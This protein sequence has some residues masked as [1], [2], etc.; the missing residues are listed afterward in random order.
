MRAEI[1][2]ICHKGESLIKAARDAPE[3]WYI[4]LEEYERIREMVRET[5]KE[6][7]GLRNDVLVWRWVAG[8]LLAALIAFCR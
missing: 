5:A 6:A 7:K 2:A 4:P 8:A 1:D 3:K